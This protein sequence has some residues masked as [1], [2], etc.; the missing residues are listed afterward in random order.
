M[1][2]NHHDMETNAN[3]KPMRTE[4]WALEVIGRPVLDILTMMTIILDLENMIKTLENP[5]MATIE[6][7]RLDTRTMHDLEMNRYLGES[8]SLIAI[9]TPH[10]TQ[11]FFMEYLFL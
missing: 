4:I 11:S 3:T 10:Q 6:T 9:P 1:K 2:D 8:Y 5:T 7:K